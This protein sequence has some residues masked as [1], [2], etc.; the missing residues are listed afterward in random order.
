MYHS[1]GQNTSAIFPSGTS[2]F[3]WFR[4]PSGASEEPCAHRLRLCEKGAEADWLHTPKNAPKKV[5]GRAPAASPIEKSPQ[6]IQ[7]RSAQPLR[8]IKRRPAAGAVPAQRTPGKGRRISDAFRRASPSRHPSGSLFHGLRRK[9]RTPAAKNKKSGR[10]GTPPYPAVRRAPPTSVPHT[11][12][13]RKT[14]HF[15]SDRSQIKRLTRKPAFFR[16]LRPAP[17]KNAAERS[18]RS[19]KNAFSPSFEPILLRA[20]TENAT[21]RIFPCPRRTMG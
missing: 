16:V 10:R 12:N 18:R 19:V 13:G 7:Y 17:R 1:S 8:S 11:R 4:L 20:L 9:I 14:R 6:H 21:G 15:R 5:R 2:N 3:H